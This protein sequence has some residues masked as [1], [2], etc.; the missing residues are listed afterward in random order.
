MA[1]YYFSA[2][3]SDATGNGTI[4]NPWKDPSYSVHAN[5]PANDDT[6]HLDGTTIQLSGQIAP[7]GNFT[8]KGVKPGSSCII[9]NGSDSP[10]DYGAATGG[11]FTLTI[12]DISLTELL[13]A[14]SAQADVLI[15][16]NSSDTDW[17]CNIV[18]TRATLA[19]VFDV[20]YNQI[21][22]GTGKTI[23]V[24]DSFLFSYY[25]I[26]SLYGV[27]VVGSKSTF[28]SLAFPGTGNVAE[29]ARA[30]AA[31]GTGSTFT[32]CRFIGIGYEDFDVAGIVDAGNTV[33]VTFTGCTIE[34]YHVGPGTGSGHLY[35]IKVNNSTYTFVNCAWDASIQTVTG[36]GNIDG[37]P[38]GG[39]GPWPIIGN[40][41]GV[42][43]EIGPFPV[44]QI[45]S[46]PFN[47]GPYPVQ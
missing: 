34:A 37:F 5:L 22:D 44:Q 10:I 11:G 1:T 17:C 40:A 2:N 3:G 4:G 47:I 24:T 18:C 28:L 29:E 32:N 26:F 30:L 25:D 16:P 27:K 46:G 35:S 12:Q 21:K 39:V 23:T 43:T 33:T 7:L 31:V 13:Q 41:L 8:L 9:G 36:T 19:G 15:K 14:G 38:R 6:F 42:C 20:F 45:G